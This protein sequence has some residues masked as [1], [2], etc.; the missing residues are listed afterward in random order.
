MDLNNSSQKNNKNPAQLPEGWDYKTFGDLFKESKMIVEDLGYCP[1][2]YSVTN[3]GIQLREGKYTKELSK[4]TSKYK[5]AKRGDM[6]FGLSRE[7]PNLDVFPDSFGAFSPAYIIYSPSDYRIGLLVGCIMR[8]KLMEQVDILKGGAREGKTLDKEK[9][10]TKRFAIPKDE[11]L[12][13]L[14]GMDH[15]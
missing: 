10:Q 11:L 8:L 6:V 7:I 12:N 13:T 4:S 3:K 9:L 5:I 14:W 1:K 15:N 2:I